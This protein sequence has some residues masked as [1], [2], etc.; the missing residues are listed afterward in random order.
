M[1]KMKMEPKRN[2]IEKIPRIKGG[3]ER[4]KNYHFLSRSSFEFKNPQ[5]REFQILEPAAAQMPYIEIERLRSIRSVLLSTLQMDTT[6]HHGV[7]TLI[8]SGF[9]AGELIE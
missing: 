6:W 5:E 7:R 8:Y 4:K 9:R 2:Q 1:K 3:G